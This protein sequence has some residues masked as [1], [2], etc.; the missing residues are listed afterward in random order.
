MKIGVEPFDDLSGR[1]KG[2]RCAS[3][4]FWIMV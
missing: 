4:W 1:Q 2:R 3:L